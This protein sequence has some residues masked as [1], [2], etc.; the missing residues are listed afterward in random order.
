MRT[1][2]ARARLVHARTAELRQ[3][4]RGRQRLL[5][6]V[7]VAACL[8]LVVG[9]GVCMPGWMS[10]SPAAGVGG[11]Q[12]AASLVGSSAALGYILVGLC[13]FLLGV[14]VTVLLYRLRRREA[15]TRREQDD[16]L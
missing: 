13:A 1:N 6:A 10:G 16:E 11:V 4:H 3:R 15:R 7:C 14:C 2:E 12:G 5:G 9:I 8:L